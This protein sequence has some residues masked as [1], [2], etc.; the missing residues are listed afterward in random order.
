MTEPAP[1][2]AAVTVTLKGGRDFDAPWVV[3]R[4]SQA[5]EVETLL[6]DSAN[7]DLYTKV[8]QSANAFQDEYAKLRPVASAPAQSSTRPPLSGQ[9]ALANAGPVA[10]EVVLTK[11][12]FSNKDAVKALG[13]RWSKEAVGS[14]GKPGAWVVRPKFEPDYLSKFAAYI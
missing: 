9:A 6:E 10:D 5:D 13:G 14:S 1:N 2:D 12:N 4:G 7:G 8:A 11:A 3:F